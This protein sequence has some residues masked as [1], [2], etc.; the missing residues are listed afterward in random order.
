MQALLSFVIST[1]C[2]VPNCKLCFTNAYCTE[3]EDKFFL[4]GDKC[5][6]RCPDGLMA[7]PY[8]RKCEDKGNHFL[9]IFV[10]RGA[11]RSRGR[12]SFCIG[13]FIPGRHTTTTWSWICLTSDCNPR[14]PRRRVKPVY[15]LPIFYNS[16]EWISLHSN[17]LIGGSVAECWRQVGYGLE[18]RKYGTTTAAPGAYDHRSRTP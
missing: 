9:V 15:Y 12:P 14:I 3:C 8:S 13:L 1:E 11:S 6:A 17:S 4:H 2:D 7:S 18:V 5:T 10:T 16:P